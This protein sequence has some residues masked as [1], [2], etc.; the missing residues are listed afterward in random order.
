VDDNAE[1]RTE[2]TLLYL[3]RK[4]LSVQKNKMQGPCG[5]DFKILILA[6]EAGRKS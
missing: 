2:D 5:I 6:V 1:K 3:R 4:F